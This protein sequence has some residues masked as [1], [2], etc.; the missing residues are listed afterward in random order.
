MQ[1]LFK[2]TTNKISFMYAMDSFMYRPNMR[3]H[4]WTKHVAVC[5]VHRVNTIHY[6]NVLAP[7]FCIVS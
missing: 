3:S 5:W 6:V 7:L 1:L 2:V 4:G